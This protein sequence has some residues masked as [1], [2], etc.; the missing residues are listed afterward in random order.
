MLAVQARVSSDGGCG[1]CGCVEDSVQAQEEQVSVQKQCVISVLKCV[2]V[3]YSGVL[4]CECARAV[5]V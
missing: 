4:M 1:M 2:C 5:E 3:C